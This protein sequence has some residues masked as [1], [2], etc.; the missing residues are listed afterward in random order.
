MDDD[1]LATLTGLVEA[2]RILLPSSEIHTVETLKQASQHRARTIARLADL[3]AR[4]VLLPEH[5]VA[6]AEWL[7]YRGQVAS[8]SQL[9]IGEG[10]PLGTTWDGAV[11]DSIETVDEYIDDGI[12]G[13][14]RNETDE[15]LA[16]AAARL[17]EYKRVPLDFVRDQLAQL[18][19]M[20]VEPDLDIM[21]IPSD[22]DSFTKAFP[23]VSLRRFF[24][25]H[26]TYL[27][28]NDINDLSFICRTV[29]HF[30]VVAVDRRMH[31][32][33]H[34]MRAKLPPAITQVLFHATVV[35]NAAQTMEV[36]QRL[37]G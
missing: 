1:Q 9:I 37:L 16:E 35:K 19:G 4:W 29:P 2:G 14:L 24:Y 27:E 6:V 15:V 30:D 34:A 7:A 17:E 25:A 32:R 21:K 36:I 22:E 28:R 5:V 13:E 18:L 12:S 3:R 23:S 10:Q 20:T 31:D 11:A 33:L 26:A 8:A